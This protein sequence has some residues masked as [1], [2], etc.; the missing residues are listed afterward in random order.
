MTA[1]AELA[2][3]F[4]ARAQLVA[5]VIR[6]ALARG[7]WVLCDRFI[8]SSEAYQGGG[9]GLGADVVLSMHRMLCDGLMPD[10]TVLLR[11]PVEVSLARARERRSDVAVDRFE[12]EELAFFQRSHEGFD[13]V[14]AREPARAVFNRR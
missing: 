8:D 4:A 13:G 14:A 1:T 3:L 2:L 11:S 9:R 12:C 6:P 7:A 5:E 10:L